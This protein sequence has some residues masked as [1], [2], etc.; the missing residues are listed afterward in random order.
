VI[1]GIALQLK[2]RLPRGYAGNIV[3]QRLAG[4][5]IQLLTLSGGL[6]EQRN[7]RTFKIF[8]RCV[9]SASIVSGQSDFGL[10]SSL[11]AAVHFGLV[12]KLKRMD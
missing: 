4:L 2:K 5:P 11:V 3:L 12:E 8:I 10:E 1:Y 9:K 6:S 7:S